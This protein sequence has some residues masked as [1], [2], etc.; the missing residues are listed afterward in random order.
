MTSA[1]IPKMNIPAIPMS[2]ARA[3]F[4]LVHA[5]ENSGRFHQRDEALDY[6]FEQKRLFQIA[7]MI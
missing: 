5:N 4:F 2:A 1:A 3:V 6:F 7:C